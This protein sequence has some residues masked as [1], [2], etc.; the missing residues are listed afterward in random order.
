MFY[1]WCLRICKQIFTYHCIASSADTEVVEEALIIKRKLLKLIERLGDDLPP[2]A[3]DDL[4]NQLGGPAR[5][6][7][8]GFGI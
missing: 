2:N 7:E 4:I 1:K 6:A 3:L 8:V 5:V